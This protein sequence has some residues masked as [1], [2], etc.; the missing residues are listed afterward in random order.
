MLAGDG[1]EVCEGEQGWLFLKSVGTLQTLAAARDLS[2]WRLC[3][4]P[5]HIAKYRARHERMRRRNIPFFVLFA[6][7]ASGI[8]GEHLPQP[9]KVEVPTASEELAA[10]LVGA[11]VPAISP[12]EALRAAKMGRDLYFRTDSHWTYAGAY[13][14]YRLLMEKVRAVLP[15]REIADSELTYGERVGYGDL[16]VHVTPERKAMLQT[17]EV[18]SDDVVVVA[19]TYDQR[20]KS[21][22]RTRC[23]SGVGRALI[24]R[25]SFA[26]FLMPFI[27]R[28]FAETIMIAPAPAMPDDAIDLYQP[29]I[30]ILEVAERALFNV[31][32]PFND[33]SARSFAQ[34]YLESELN[35]HGGKHQVASVAA[36]MRGDHLEAVA[37]AATAILLEKD[38]AQAHNLAWA[39]W[40][41]NQVKLCHDVTTAA[42][43]VDPTNRFLYY[44]RSS[45]LVLLG[46]IDDGLA[47]LDRALEL[48]PDNAQYL[49]SRGE[50]LSKAGKHEHAA[51]SLER[52]LAAEPT[53]EPAWLALIAIYRLLARPVEADHAVERAREVFGE[54]WVAPARIDTAK[55]S[56]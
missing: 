4:L 27:E 7:E 41:A 18:A 45:A 30:V 46:K 47:N 5:R 32:P 38:Q 1:I 11:G 34:D 51:E 17:V 3:Y 36:L 42:V 9:H 52:S 31:E 56:E 43:E 49:F 23:A 19:S 50:W 21:L 35:P 14:A 13:V 22:R 25:D 6:P 12:S 8:Y 55:V 39:L 40:A 24:I 2:G 54:T 15:V 10:A 37:S 16:A 53:Y 48:Q 26:Q 28:T 20:E 33:W 29:D 44:L